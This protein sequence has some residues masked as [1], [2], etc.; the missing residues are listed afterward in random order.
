[1]QALEFLCQNDKYRA[2]PVGVTV[3]FIPPFPSG[4]TQVCAKGLEVT[5][6]TACQGTDKRKGGTSFCAPVATE[7]THSPLHGVFSFSGVLS[8]M[9]EPAVKCSGSSGPTDSKLVEHMLCRIYFV[10][11]NN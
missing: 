9:C 3:T 1:M 5:E 4:H 8:V 6:S 11:E 10:G 7:G 2:K